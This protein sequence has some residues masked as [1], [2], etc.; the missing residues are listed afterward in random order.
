VQIPGLFRYQFRWTKGINLRH[1]GVQ[2]VLSLIGPRAATVFFIQ[3]TFIAQD[4]IAS[5]LAVGTVSALVYGWL[6]MQVPETIIGT[7]LGTVLLPTLS[8]QIVR[9]EEEAFRS[10][11]NRVL[12]VILAL[13]IPIAVLIAVGIIPV[14]GLLGFDAAG[15][16]MVV[17]T[18][19]AY[20]LGLMGH[21]L[22]EVSARAFYAQQNA[23]T[24]LVAAGLTAAAFIVLAI[25]LGLRFGA[26][27]IALANALAFSGEAILLWVLLNRRYNGI[28]QVGSTLVR[29]LLAGL[30]AGVVVFLVLRLSA[31]FLES[32]G[33]ILQVGAALLAM[34]L[35]ALAALP[36]VWREVRLLARL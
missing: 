18:A 33:V 25:V 31:G 9:G 30:S 4:N 17:W 24:P 32:S 13:T 15:T 3:L 10:S 21:S 20:L 12:R 16:A 5:R 8:E 1:P 36:F 27:G 28:L 6:F 19:R 14:V 35:G 11:L 2:Q 26:P 22:L 29:A 7:A 23:R 34:S